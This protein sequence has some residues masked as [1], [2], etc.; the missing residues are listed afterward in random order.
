M[1]YPEIAQA[2]GKNHSSVVLGVQRFEKL[3]AS[4]APLCWTSP[5]GAKSV[6]PA[7]LIDMLDG[8]LR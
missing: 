6:Q 8:Q 4:G 3:L 5:A 7:E 2:L 1:S